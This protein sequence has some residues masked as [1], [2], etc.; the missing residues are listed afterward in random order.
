MNTRVNLDNSFITFDSFRRSFI[1]AGRI[2]LQGSAYFD[3]P[4]PAAP[5]IFD[6]VLY[7][8]LS[9][10]GKTVGLLHASV[11]CAPSFHSGFHSLP[12]AAAVAKAGLKISSQCETLLKQ[13]DPG[14]TAFSSPG[15]GVRA[16]RCRPDDVVKALAMGLLALDSEAVVTAFLLV[17]SRMENHVKNMSWSGR[18]SLVLDACRN[19]SIPREGYGIKKKSPYGGDEYMEGTWYVVDPKSNQLSQ[20]L[21]GSRMAPRLPHRIVRTASEVDKSQ[22]HKW[23]KPPQSSMWPWTMDHH[24]FLCESSPIATAHHSMMALMDPSDKFGGNGGSENKAADVCRR[25]PLVQDQLTMDKMRKLMEAYFQD[26]A[27]TIDSSNP[28][29]GEWHRS[30]NDL[31]W[32]GTSRY[33]MSPTGP[34]ESPAVMCLVL[35]VR[36]KLDGRNFKG[37]VPA[38]S[39]LISNTERFYCRLTPQQINSSDPKVACV[40]MY[41]CGLISAQDFRNL[42]GKSLEEHDPA[43]E[44]G[45]VTVGMGPLVT[46]LLPR[47]SWYSGARKALSTAIAQEGILAPLSQADLPPSAAADDE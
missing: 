13:L 14:S 20:G 41:S 31:R 29:Y 8:P 32:V 21:I 47:E 23:R 6:K 28:R 40:V 39:N 36:P 38:E 3:G 2:P 9:V 19:N 27:A 22:V 43:L 30:N 46:A 42:M 1:V 7:V 37:F 15:R 33:S 44:A 12:D 35:G 45:H 4:D 17:D 34:E 26:I 25:L 16:F 18:A 10:D 11:S 24:W 5:F